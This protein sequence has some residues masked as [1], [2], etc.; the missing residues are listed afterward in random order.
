MISIIED[1]QKFNLINL[2]IEA[3]IEIIPKS[4][5]LHPVENEIMILYIKDIYSDNG[6]VI[7]ISH[8]DRDFIKLNDVLQKVKNINNIYVLDKK[9]TM[10]Y[11]YQKNIHEQLFFTTSFNKHLTPTHNYFY[12]KNIKWANELIPIEKH[13]ESCEENYF[14]LKRNGFH[15][16][17][18]VYLDKLSKVFNYIESN[19]IKTDPTLYKHYFNKSTE[20][21]VYTQYKLDT[22]T[23]RPSNSFGGVNFAALKKDNNER[24]CFIP[25]NDFFME[26]DISAY[27]PCLL[28]HLFNYDFPIND[29]HQYFADLYG[30]DYASS[31]QITFQ[32]TY[33]NVREEYKHLEF[34]KKLTKFKDDLWKEFESNGYVTCPISNKKF[35]E[36]ELEDMRPSKLLNYLLQALETATNVEILWDVIK[37]LKNKKTKIVLYTYDSILLDIDKDD[38]HILPLIEQIFTNRKLTI[39]FN[40]GTN[41]NFN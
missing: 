25:R 22:K 1:I 2:P 30:V 27:H 24:E 18:S 14:N 13:V 29:I 21:Y 6:Y 16:E 40:K 4:H 11:F 37:L 35:I 34:F 26:M 32:Q 41:Y 23:S 8:P 38:I 10:H 17:D 15:K 31:K 19:G 20:G 33:G 9:S 36:Y 7:N 3:Y 28:S 39:K 5:T 12:N